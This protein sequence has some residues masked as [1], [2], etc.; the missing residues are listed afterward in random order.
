MMDI[1]QIVFLLY[2]SVGAFYGY[3]FLQGARHR[4]SIFVELIFVFLCWPILTVFGCAVWFLNRKK[5]DPNI[6]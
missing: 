2:L 3:R 5:N 6:S 1:L 4:P